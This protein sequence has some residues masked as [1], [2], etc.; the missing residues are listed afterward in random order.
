[1]EL[2]VAV[3]FFI[4]LAILAPRFGHDSRSRLRSAEEHLAASGVTWETDELSAE[5]TPGRA[6]ADRAR[7]LAHIPKHLVLSVPTALLRACRPAFSRA[8][9]RFPS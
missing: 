3:S 2:L 5:R 6:P 7:V 1:M 9:A 8:S 4:G